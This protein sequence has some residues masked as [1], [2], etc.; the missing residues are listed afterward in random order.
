VRRTILTSREFRGFIVGGVVF[1]ALALLP[2]ILT[3]TQPHPAGRDL[4]AAFDGVLALLFSGAMTLIG[5]ALIV[6]AVFLR[7]GSVGGSSS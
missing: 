3:F 6:A 2:W 5:V 4:S 7:R 1:V